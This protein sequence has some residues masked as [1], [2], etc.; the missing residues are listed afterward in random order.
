MPTIGAERVPPAVSG[1]LLVA[2]AGLLL[3]RGQSVLEHVD[4]QLSCVG[5]DPAVC[6]A[7]GYRAEAAAAR[8]ALAPYVER[9]RAAGAPVPASF[10]QDVTPGRLTAGPIDAGFLLGDSSEG[11]YLVLNSYLDKACFETAPSG[12]QAEWSAMITWLDPR[13]TKG[14][15]GDSGLPLV[16][17]GPSTPAQRAW[18]RHV[19]ADLSACG[20]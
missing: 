2:A 12:V 19:I 3:S 16:A 6:V 15:G 10:G 1:V 17:R 18:V 7:P 20:R 14:S 13:V 8:K 11:P 4:S 5:A 9:L